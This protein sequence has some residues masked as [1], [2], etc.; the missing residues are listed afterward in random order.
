MLKNLIT[1]IKNNPGRVFGLVYPYMLVLLTGLGL[2]YI[3]NLDQVARQKVPVILAVEET[4]KE[5]LKFIEARVV[6][7]VDVKVIGKP[8]QELIEK[9]RVL[10]QAN[11][12]S[13]HGDEGVGA[14]PAA[15]GLNPAPTNLT[16]ADNWK[17]GSKISGIYTTLEE[18][19]P[20]T[21]MI[22][23]DFMT[24][25]ERFALTH[26]IRDAFVPDPP[27]DTD[28]ELAA[29]DQLYHLSEGLQLPAQIP[30]DKAIDLVVNENRVKAQK[31]TEILRTI[32]EDSKNE[33]VSLFESIVTSKGEAVASLVSGKDWVNNEQ[34]FVKMVTSTVNQ[35]GFTGKVFNL[36]DTEWTMLFN[37]FNR[38][39]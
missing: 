16:V 28:D 27:Q 3:S 2:Y 11:C 5:E 23:Y 22:A 24:P 17:N 15:I 38:L 20:G 1:V 10:Y 13:C 21:G 19:I 25:E 8:S 14:G 26:Y 4:V 9:G 30:L 31:I 39:M 32:S 12:S 36:S 33:A 6:P 18:G 7:P 35:N 34:K 37:Y 29:L